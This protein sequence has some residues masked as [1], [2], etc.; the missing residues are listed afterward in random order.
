MGQALSNGFTDT[1]QGT[2]PVNTGD[3]ANATNGVNSSQNAQNAFAQALQGQNGLGNQTTAFN[4]GQNILGQQEGLAAQLQNLASGQGPNPAAAQ[5][6]QATNANNQQAAGLIASSKGI[7]PA[8]AAKLA[9]QQSVNNNQN[10]AMQASQLY[11]QQQLG[12]LN[13][14]QGQQSNIAN[15]NAQQAGLA[16]TQ[17]GNVQSGLNSA[18]STALGNQ[19]TTYGAQSSYN[20]QLLGADTSNQN[21]QA[22]ALGGLLK[23]LGAVVG[24]ANG[25]QVP[26]N[27]DSANAPTSQSMHP[28]TQF[29]MGS[30]PQ[31]SMFSHGGHVHQRGFQPKTPV[32]LSPGEK[33][34]SPK[35]AQAVAKGGRIEGKGKVV[36]GK[37]KVKGD[38]SKNDTVPAELP[39]GG[40]VIPR[41]KMAEGPEA[42]SRFVHAIMAK[43]NLKKK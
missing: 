28:V 27:L 30:N 32:I 22:N 6:Q 19:G 29:L 24:M 13:A 10:A 42:A 14:L 40:V 16:N 15:T 31:P 9:G 33:A 36:P 39:P 1:S 38:S 26:S 37:A 25:G 43:H 4:Q 2:N 17:V 35:E 21:T 18:A 8:I 12:A 5:L 34:L 41:S 3:I 23:G 11:Q 7:N 20:G